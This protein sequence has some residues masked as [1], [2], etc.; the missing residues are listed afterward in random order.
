VTVEQ[1][2]LSAHG[3]SSINT[4]ARNHS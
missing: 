3:L 4:F 1:N 2:G